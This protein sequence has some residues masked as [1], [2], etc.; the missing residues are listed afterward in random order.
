MCKIR[1]GDR[2]ISRGIIDVGKDPLTLGTDHYGKPFIEITINGV[3]ELRSDADDVR[4]LLNRGPAKKREAFS[5]IFNRK[6]GL[7]TRF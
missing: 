5:R 4:V 7:L 2:L 6:K 3:T 1:G